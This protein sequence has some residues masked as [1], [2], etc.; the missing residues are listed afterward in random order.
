MH[1]YLPVLKSKLQELLLSLITL[2]FLL[3]SGFLQS[4]MSNFANLNQ[5]LLV[6]ILINCSF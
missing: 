4:L 1:E 3:C 5:Q 2:S 6:H